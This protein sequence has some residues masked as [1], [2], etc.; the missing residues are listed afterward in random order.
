MVPQ[1]DEDHA[2]VIAAG[3]PGGEVLGERPPV[4]AGAEEPVED[5]SG[6]ARIRVRVWDLFVG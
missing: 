2:P 3:D 5:E 4:A 6:G 1:V